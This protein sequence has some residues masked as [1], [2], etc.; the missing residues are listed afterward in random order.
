MSRNLCTNRCAYCDVDVRL[1]ESPRLIRKDEAGC[2]YNEYR[3]M[4][5]ANAVCDACGAKYLA[6][7]WRQ[8]AGGEHDDLSFRSTFNDEPGPSDL[9]RFSFVAAKVVTPML[10]VTLRWRPYLDGYGHNPWWDRTL[11]RRVWF[12]LARRRGV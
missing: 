10:H 4:L 9:P 2:Y 12:R 3:Q 8:A 7:Y 11:V 1:E 6:W 5:V